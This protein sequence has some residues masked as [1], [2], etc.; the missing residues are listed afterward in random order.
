MN[1]DYT[2][3]STSTASVKAGF[4]VSAKL[5]FIRPFCP[6]S[7]G[8][9]HPDCRKLLLSNCEELLVGTASKRIS[10]KKQLGDSNQLEFAMLSYM[11]RQHFFVISI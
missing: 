3:S 4:H 10:K 5:G 1:Y 9:T 2:A 8:K 7:Y 6:T 11:T